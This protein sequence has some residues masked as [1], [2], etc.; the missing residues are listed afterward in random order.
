MRK[1]FVVLRFL[2]LSAKNLNTTPLFLSLGNLIPYSRYLNWSLAG[3]HRQVDLPAQL[4]PFGQAAGLAARIGDA[5]VVQ[6][7]RQV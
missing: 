5:Q 7:G 6:A 2:A 1:G 3:N 4:E